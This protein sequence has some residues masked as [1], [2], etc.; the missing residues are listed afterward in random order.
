MAVKISNGQTYMNEFDKLNV[1]VGREPLIFLLFSCLIYIFLL[2]MLNETIFFVFI[3]IE[4]NIINIVL[5]FLLTYFIFL[6]VL[7]SNTIFRC[8]YYGKQDSHYCYSKY[9]E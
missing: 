3:K 7:K 9:C 2:L 1:K 8:N 5:L 4:I 6:H